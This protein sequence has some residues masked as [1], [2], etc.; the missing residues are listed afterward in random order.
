MGTVQHLHGYNAPTI[1]VQCN[2]FLST[3]HQLLSQGYKEIYKYIIDINKI[4]YKYKKIML[5][6][7]AKINDIINYN[8][9][10]KK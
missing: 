4:I 5:I 1:W 6:I 2:N 9:K 8:K 3:V 7:I 10:Y